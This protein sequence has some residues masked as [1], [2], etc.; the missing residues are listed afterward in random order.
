M[1]RVVTLTPNPALDLSTAVERI[2]PMLKL[3]CTTQ[4]RDPGGGGVNVARVV[5]RFGGDVEA[6]LPAGGA[7]G[8]MLRRLIED[9]GVPNRIIPVEAA[10]RED[11]SVTELST[12]SQYRFVLPGQPLQEA[13]WRAC[14]A[15]LAAT[16]PAPQL[17]VGSG[18][19]PPGVPSNFY[20]QAAAI[21]ATRG[22]RFLVDTSGPALT[23]AI[24]HG[25]NLIKPS[26]NEMRQ[27]IGAKSADQAECIAAARGLI[28]SGRVQI[29]VLSLAHLGAVLITKDH[30]LRA[31]AIP[32]E[33][34]SS[35]G[36]GDSF[37]GAMVFS[38]AKGESLVDAFRLGAAAG[39]A[40]LIHEG[41]ELCPAAE[42]Y[43]LRAQVQIEFL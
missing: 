13:D 14:L 15:A 6:I 19:L 24:E 16:A 4:R 32:I 42:A 18:S 33:A 9:E 43:R 37:L 39:A 23:A 25:V 22:A 28:D 34:K 8:D 30:V 2:V 1:A 36:A 10:T 11:F 31:P 5:K 12:G 38:I 27:L 7:T 35:V 20:A 26:L 21:A 29:V 41:T 3:R 17:I 40:A